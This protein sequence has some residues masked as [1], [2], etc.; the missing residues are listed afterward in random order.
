MRSVT[1]RP[2]TANNY[3]IDKEHTSWRVDLHRSPLQ[4]R[5]ALTRIEELES[6]RE[7]ILDKNIKYFEIINNLEKQ[8]VKEKKFREELVSIFEEQDKEKESTIH[9]HE[10]E[11]S[12]LQNIIQHMENESTNRK[13]E[14]IPIKRKN[15][16]S[17]TLATVIETERQSYSSYILSQ[18]AELKNRQSQLELEMQKFK[19]HQLSQ[20]ELKQRMS[21]E[22]GRPLTATTPLL[23]SPIHSP[24]TKRREDKKKTIFSSEKPSPYLREAKMTNTNHNLTLS[25]VG[26]SQTQTKKL[27]LTTSQTLL[28]ARTEENSLQN[29]NLPQLKTNHKGNTKNLIKITHQN[30]DRISNKIER[31]VH[32]LSD[33]KPALIILTEHGLTEANLQLTKLV[34]YSLVGGFCRKNHLKGGVTAYAK[35]EL[36]DHV[37]LISTSDEISELTCET[38]LYE[39]KNGNE[40]L[41]VLGVYRPPGSNINDVIDVLTE[42]LDKTL[43]KDNKLLIIKT[44]INETTKLNYLLG[45]Y[46]IERLTLPPTRITPT[47]QR[48]IDWVCTNFGKRPR[49][50]KSKALWDIINGER[51]AKTKSNAKLTLNIEGKITE[52]PRKIAL[53][54]SSPILLRKPYNRINKYL[55]HNHSNIIQKTDSFFSSQLQKMKSEE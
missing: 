31:I 2:A 5:T 46:N 49:R 4:P 28:E 17:Q 8:L 45:S 35:E 50:N 51:K 25:M 7:T 33:N 13:Y 3:G 6:Q 21:Q 52:D 37:K 26:I 43:G 18:F 15:A 23:S 53:I 1:A 54:T 22:R 19:E 16:E 55:L 38:A 10:S 41:L 42:V 48:S 34:N 44:D 14:E 12:R 30:I 27:S 47:S 32:F 11:I 39:L 9:N 24:R 20:F 29:K 40:S 36:T